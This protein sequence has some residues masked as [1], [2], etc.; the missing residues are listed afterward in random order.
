MFQYLN[1]FCFTLSAPVKYTSVGYLVL[2]VLY[3]S[4]CCY[5]NSK[6]TLNIFRNINI[7]ENKNYCEVNNIKSDYDACR[8]GAYHN[9]GYYFFH[10]IIFPFSV[11]SHSIPFMVLLF[12]PCN[13]CND[14][15]N[16]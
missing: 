7:D 4:S 6:K 12:N 10:S 13:N 11:V 2:S 15:S 8:F 14:D 1:K 5:Y 16:N 9:F 3:T